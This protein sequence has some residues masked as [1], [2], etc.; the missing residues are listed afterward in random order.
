MQRTD[1][2]VHRKSFFILRIFDL[3]QRLAQLGRELRLRDRLDEKIE[4]IDL[5]AADGILRHVRDEN[6]DGVFIHLAQFFRGGEAVE[7]R[8]IDVH[9]HEI[10]LAAV[11]ADKC[12]P[13]CKFGNGEALACFPLKFFQIGTEHLGVF[14]IIFYDRDED[15]SASS[16]KGNDCHSG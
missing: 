10:V 16:L 7:V 4:R 2:S 13:V 8:H 14:R 3:S 1:S 6:D 5:V 11:I 15:H 9:Q 12:E